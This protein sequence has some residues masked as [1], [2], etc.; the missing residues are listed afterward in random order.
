LLEAALALT[1][2]ERADLAKK[3]LASVDVDPPVTT[4]SRPVIE[5]GADPDVETA[6]A[7]EIVRRVERIER[8]EAKGTPVEEVRAR[9]LA[10]FG[11]R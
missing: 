6:W 3:L 10:R 11:H 7:D 8:G 2:D 4:G 9:M 5:D 1:R